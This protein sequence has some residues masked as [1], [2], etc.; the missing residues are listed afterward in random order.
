LTVSLMPLTRDLILLSSLEPEK[1]AVGYG[2]GNFMTSS[3]RLLRMGMVGGGPGSFVGPIHRIAAELD[4]TMALVAGAFSRDPDQ[5]RAGGRSLGLA[6]DRVYATYTEM[7][8]RERERPDPIDFVVIATPNNLHL[9]IAVAALEQG[10][11]V[12]SDK[13]ATATLDEAQQ[14]ERAIAR[15]GGLY[16][17]TFNYTGYAMVREAREICRS[18]HLGKIRKVVV[19]YTQGWLNERLETTGHKQ[20]TWRA[21][22]AQ[23]GPG[24]CIGDIGVHAFNLLEF[25]SGLE[26]KEICPELS[27]VVPGRTLDDDCNV[28]LRMD[29]GAPGVLHSSQIAAGERNHLH[30]RIYGEKGGLSWLQEIPDRLELKWSNK[31]CQTLHAA[32]TYLSAPARAVMRIPAGHPEGFLEGF[33]NVYRN[34]GEALRARWQDPAAKPS[35]LLPMIREGVRSMA[36]LQRAVDGNGKGWVPLAL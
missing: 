31:P 29:N 4:G 19:E 25:V 6:E 33:A 8:A 9:P 11:A 36:F 20:A 13:P 12:L 30:L 24:G 23:N 16:A 15:T 34:F 7:L 26:V 21:D 27:S 10:Y 5:S 32:S 28:L 17:L 3:Q 1:E 35:P 2:S 14:I 18:G 22:P